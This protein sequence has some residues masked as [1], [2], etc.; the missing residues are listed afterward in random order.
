MLLSEYYQSGLIEIYA[1]VY[2]LA[3]FVSN[4]TVISVIYVSETEILNN[5]DILTKKNEKIMDNYPGLTLLPA[6]YFSFI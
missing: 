1:N 2:A 4:D 6:L 3:V 5:T